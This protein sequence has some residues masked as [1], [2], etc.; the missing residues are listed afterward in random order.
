M[1]QCN[2]LI[3]KAIKL[4]GC[5]NFHYCVKAITTNSYTTFRNYCFENKLYFPNSEIISTVIYYLTVKQH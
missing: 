3:S 5:E 2:E 1:A 4:Q